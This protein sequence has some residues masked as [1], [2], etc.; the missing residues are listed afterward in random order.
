[1][2]PCLDLMQFTMEAWLVTG[3]R[4]LL[5]AFDLV[6]CGCFRKLSNR[7]CRQR[8]FALI[9]ALKQKTIPSMHCSQS[10]SSVRP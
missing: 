10:V 9:R 4:F 1:M 2:R 3:K 8:A 7:K 6:D 5:V